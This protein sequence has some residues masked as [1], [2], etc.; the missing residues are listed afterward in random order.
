MDQVIK[1]HHLFRIILNSSLIRTSW[2]ITQT[3]KIVWEQWR[4][5]IIH[6]NHKPIQI[7]PRQWLENNKNFPLSKILFK[8]RKVS[9]LAAQNN[10]SERI[11]DRCVAIVDRPHPPLT[12]SQVNSTVLYPY[13]QAVQIL[14]IA[15]TTLIK[16]PLGHPP[17][18]SKRERNIRS[19]RI[20]SEWKASS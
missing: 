15:I 2:Y 8:K 12:I 16:T 7:T 18:P 5:S 20:C 3:K 6:N 13:E 14:D 9:S 19:F 10:S 17:K 4:S 1:S 11:R